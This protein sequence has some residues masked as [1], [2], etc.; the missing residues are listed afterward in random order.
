MLCIATI[1]GV[2]YGQWW[3][4][5]LDLGYLLPKE[6]I[7]SHLLNTYK[8]NYVQSFDPGDNFY[9]TILFNTLSNTI[10]QI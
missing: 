8:R 5:I 4:H 1:I 10:T 6:H 7:Q 3:A 9:F 2:L